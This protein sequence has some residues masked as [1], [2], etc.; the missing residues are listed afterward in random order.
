[1]LKILEGNMMGSEKKYGYLGVL[2]ICVC[3]EKYR[4]K[5]N[6]ANVN[7]FESG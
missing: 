4:D 1:M 2:C 7:N 5:A 6:V 3:R